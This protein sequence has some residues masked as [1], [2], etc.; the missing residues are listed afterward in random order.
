M[1]GCVLVRGGCVLAEGWH[2]EFGGPHGEVDALERT[3]EDTVGAT[4][5]VSL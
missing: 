4:A 1:V 2:R 3:G 5:Y